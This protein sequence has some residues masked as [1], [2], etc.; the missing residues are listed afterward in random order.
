[1]TILALLF[2]T[3]FAT[4]APIEP[5]A[6]EMLDNFVAGRFEAATKDFTESMR[7]TVTPD[8]LA[9]IKQQME[10]EVGAYKSVAQ[11]QEHRDGTSRVLDFKLT[12]EKG[13][14][15]MRVVFDDASR[16]AAVFFDP[17]V[18]KPDPILETHA[19]ELFAAFMSG[20]FEIA[21]RNFDAAMRTQLPPAKFAQLHKQ[22]FE[23]FGSFKAITK[24]EQRNETRARIIDLTTSWD[25]ATVLVSVTFDRQ[26]RVNGLRI[27]PQ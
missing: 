12:C 25:K 14:L 7:K 10:S 18:V 2:S 3:F 5:I 13:P 15:A 1:M 26:S 23:A 4:R 6:R 22:T 11:I 17:L 9:S 19:R 16:I 20:Q 21:S 8:V 27:G 24:V